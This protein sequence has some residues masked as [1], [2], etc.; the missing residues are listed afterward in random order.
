[1]TTT[2]TFSAGTAATQRFDRVRRRT[3]APQENDA[4]TLARFV[5]GGI[6]DIVS[7]FVEIR[8]GW[9]IG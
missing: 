7:I 9:K 3:H 5:V 4:G 1:V 8:S 2:T 6:E